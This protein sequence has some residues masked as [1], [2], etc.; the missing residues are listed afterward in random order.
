MDKKTIPE[1]ISASA[2]TELVLVVFQGIMIDLAEKQRVFP[3]PQCSEQARVF[4]FPGRA[5][6]SSSGIVRVLRGGR[7][8]IQECGA[9]SCAVYCF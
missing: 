4:V 5:P 1:F 8:L 2:E 6:S 3:S 7:L 9:T